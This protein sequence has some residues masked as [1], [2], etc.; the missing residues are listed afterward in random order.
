MKE[1]HRIKVVQLMAYIY[2]SK[3]F[4]FFF[5]TFFLDY[6]IVYK[7]LFIEKESNMSLLLLY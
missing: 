3:F 5:P 6:L 4:F 1:R 2:K 7:T